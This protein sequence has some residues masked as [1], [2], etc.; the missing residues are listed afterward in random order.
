MGVLAVIGGGRLWGVLVLG[1]RWFGGELEGV[2]GYWEGYWRCALVRVRGGKADLASTGGGRRGE[3]ITIPHTPRTNSSL[4]PL[5]L[6]RLCPHRP[7]TPPDFHPPPYLPQ[8]HLHFPPL[9]PLKVLPDH[10][11]FLEMPRVMDVPE[12]LCEALGLEVADEALLLEGWE[13][14]GEKQEEVF[15]RGER[16]V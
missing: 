16:Q 8:H 10:G 12:H 4:L 9:H 15:G 7:P 2:L 6:P 11:L 14:G 5:P 13:E 1:W 3:S